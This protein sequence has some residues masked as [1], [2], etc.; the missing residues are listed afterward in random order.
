MIKS[1]NRSAHQRP[2]ELVSRPDLPACRVPSSQLPGGQGPTIFCA[3]TED[4]LFISLGS[5][6]GTVLF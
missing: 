4:T 2:T 6:E 3:F 5:R 1:L